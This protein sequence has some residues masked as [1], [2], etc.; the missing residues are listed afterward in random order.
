MKITPESAGLLFPEIRIVEEDDP[1]TVTLKPHPAMIVTYARD[2][3][4]GA[5]SAGELRT[6]PSMRDTI[7][8]PT[9]YIGKQWRS[10]TDAVA[11]KYFDQHPPQRL[12]AE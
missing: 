2:P 12:A 7:G 8:D 11:K 1:N 4:T 6:D 9:G 5:V 3:E 10:R